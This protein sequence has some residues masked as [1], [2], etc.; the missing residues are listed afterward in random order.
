M[1]R[2]PGTRQRGHRELWI[3]G[4]LVLP[5]VVAG[6]VLAGMGVLVNPPPTSVPAATPPSP[7][8]TPV[9][10]ATPAPGAH[11]FINEPGVP[12]VIA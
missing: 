12:F 11:R 10:G 5:L 1:N 8:A 9:S 2:I 4:L 7:V 6:F 3:V